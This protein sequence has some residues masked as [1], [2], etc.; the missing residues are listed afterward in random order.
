[1][2]KELLESFYALRTV[3]WRRAFLTNPSLQAQVHQQIS[4]DLAT[5]LANTVREVAE[6]LHPEQSIK[7][8]ADQRQVELSDRRGSITTCFI[9]YHA[10]YKRWQKRSTKTTASLDDFYSFIEPDGSRE[11]AVEDMLREFETPMALLLKKDIAARQLIGSRPHRDD[12]FITFCS[13]LFARK[14]ATVERAKAVLA[15]DAE[16]WLTEITESDRAFQDFRSEYRGALGV[17]FPNVINYKCL[18]DGFRISATRAGGLGVAMMS[19]RVFADHLSAIDVNFL[20]APEGGLQFITAD[21]R[22]SSS[23]RLRAQMS[24]TT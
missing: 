4:A 23:A 13:L 16:R 21:V 12:L 2:E 9:N 11:D 14:P 19:S 3:S 1:L 8:S 20:F 6:A 15:A 24:L 5:D 7:L 10:R 17:E 22:T 18:R